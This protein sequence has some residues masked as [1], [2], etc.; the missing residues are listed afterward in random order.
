MFT[1]TNL[2]TI[3]S[4][5][6]MTM[7]GWNESAAVERTSIAQTLVGAITLAICVFYIAVNSAKGV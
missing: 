2:E 3:G 7:F 4:P 5:L 6:A 1:Q